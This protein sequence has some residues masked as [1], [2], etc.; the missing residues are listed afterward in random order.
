[1][2]FVNEEKVRVSCVEVA[3]FATAI[4]G[5]RNPMDSWDKS[6]SR[7]SEFGT[8]IIGDNDMY[9]ARKLIKAGGEH[10]KF[11]RQ[12]YVGFD[13]VLPRYLWSE[14]DTYGFCPKNS[15]STMHKL[16]RKERCIREDQFVYHPYDEEALQDTIRQLNVLRALYFNPATEDKNEILRRAKALLPEGFLQRRTVATNY[17]QLRNIYHQRKNHRLPCWTQVICPFIES[18]PYAQELIIG[19]ER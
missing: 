10:R 11:L 1:M 16:F 14:F 17:E 4:R 3:G 2:S 13:V 19:G 18:L 8:F 12:I 5:M 15:C 7:L 9:L 6:D